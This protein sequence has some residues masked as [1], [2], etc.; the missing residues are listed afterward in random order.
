MAEYFA[1]TYALVEI[2]K[3]NPNYGKYSSAELYTTEFNL[4]E[5]PY[6]LVRD[7]GVEKAEGILEIVKSSVTVVVPE[8]HHYV[9]ASEIRIQERKNEKKLSLI[10]CLGYVIAKS[11]G[12]RFLTGDREFEGMANVEFVK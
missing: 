5:L 3:G 9:L 4:L 1:D 10:D 7:F 8:V 6:A 12:M 11:L 2:L